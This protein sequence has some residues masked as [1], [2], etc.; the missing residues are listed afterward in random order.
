MFGRKSYSNFCP[1]LYFGPPPNPKSMWR[2]IRIFLI[3]VFFFP[4]LGSS[5]PLIFW[6]SGPL[7][8]WSSGPLVLWSR[9][10]VVT[11]V[12][13][14]IPYKLLTSLNTDTLGPRA[15]VGRRLDHIHC[16][17][18]HAFMHACIHMLRMAMKMYMKMKMTMTAVRTVVA[19]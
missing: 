15:S 3:I 18:I 14:T 2:V 6:S 16:I 17:Y 12:S 1:L 7:V 11:L 13:S 10:S 8:L 9:G 19:R 4:V 5:G